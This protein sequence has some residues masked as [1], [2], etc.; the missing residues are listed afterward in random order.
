MFLAIT[1]MP[2]WSATS[3]PAGAFQQEILT[4]FTPRAGRRERGRER[5][6]DLGMKNG[7]RPDLSNL[8]P[9][10]EKR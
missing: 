3:D 4:A 9:S 10:K 1:R 5:E 2:L 7:A 6:V 8:G